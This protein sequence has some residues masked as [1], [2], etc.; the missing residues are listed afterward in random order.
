MEEAVRALME[1]SRGM[2]FDADLSFSLRTSKSEELHRQE[3]RDADIVKLAAQRMCP[4]KDYRVERWT[5]D[6]AYPNEPRSRKVCDLC[7]K[8][9]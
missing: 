5:E 7:D 1:Q 3:L 6:G 4:H 2:V 8:V 9:V